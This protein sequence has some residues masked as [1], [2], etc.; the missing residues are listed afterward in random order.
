MT[1]F[2]SKLAKLARFSVFNRRKNIENMSNNYWKLECNKTKSPCSADTKL[3]QFGALYADKNGTL[4]ENF[5]WTGQNLIGLSQII[6]CRKENFKKKSESHQ[7]N[8]TLSGKFS[9]GLSELHSI[10]LE[11]LVGRKNWKKICHGIFWTLNEYFLWEFSKLH[12][13]SNTSGFEKKREHVHFKL[14][15]AGE[16]NWLTE[17]KIFLSWY[18]M[19]EKRKLNKRQM[20]FKFSKNKTLQRP[21]VS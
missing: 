4:I 2:V 18:I 6:S 20:N 12:S 10:C 21:Y 1:K 3:S 13:T 19:T 11:E 16:K 14:A 9:A 7:K 15:N 8:H 17:V 5:G